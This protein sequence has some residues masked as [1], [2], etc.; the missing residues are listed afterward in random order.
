M[1]NLKE[2]FLNELKRRL[3]VH[4]LAVFLIWPIVS[5]GMA[6]ITSLHLPY[7][8]VS[9]GQALLFALGGMAVL[10]PDIIVVGLLGSVVSLTFF[11]LLASFDFLAEREKRIYL[12]FEPVV[13]FASVFIGASFY[14]PA[15]L[16][17]PVFSFL[18]ILPVWALSLLLFALVVAAISFLATARKRLP[19]VAIIL[20]FSF[21][22]PSLTTGRSIRLRPPL[23]LSQATNSRR[24]RNL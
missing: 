6:A 10:A 21:I 13:L 23:A 18:R 8:S 17:R 20:I 24:S 5:C 3:P 1:T 9:T 16:S 15:L 22:V 4:L 19:L 14:Y 7:Y 11:A 12:L 2:K